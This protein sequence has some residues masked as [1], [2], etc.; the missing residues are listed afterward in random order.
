MNEFKRQKK[1][2]VASNGTKDPATDEGE[3]DAPVVAR[4]DAFSEKRR[5]A[6]LRPSKISAAESRGQR[7]YQV[8]V[9]RVLARLLHDVA[10]PWY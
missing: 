9:R 6:V 4:L 8:I 7:P 5:T 3:R 1:T 10:A 2:P